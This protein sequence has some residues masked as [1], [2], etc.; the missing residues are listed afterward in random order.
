MASDEKLLTPE[1]QERFRNF[2]TGHAQGWFRPYRRLNR[3]MPHNPRC[4]L[5]HAPFGGIGG[6]LFGLTPY[7][8]SRKNPR[9]CKI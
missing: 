4:K 3:L 2:C 5:C 6:K 8:P 7:S 1:E 9:F